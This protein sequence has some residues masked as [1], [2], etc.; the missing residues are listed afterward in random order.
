MGHAFPVL[1]PARALLHSCIPR[2]LPFAPPNPAAGRPALFV[3][4]WATMTESDFLRPDIIGYGSFAFLMQTAGTASPRLVRRGTLPGSRTTMLPHIAQVLRLLPG[5][6]GTLASSAL[7][8][9]R[10]PPSR[11]RRHPGYESCEAQW[12]ACEL[13]CRRF[14]AALTDDRGIAL[15][16]D[17]VRYS[18]I[19]R[20]APR[21]LLCR[22]P[23]HCELI[24]S[25]GEKLVSVSCPGGTIHIEEIADLNPAS[26]IHG[27]G[28]A[29][30]LYASVNP[31]GRPVAELVPDR[32]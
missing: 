24:C 32:F 12:L 13:P 4:F 29:L 9:Y 15:G 16:A 18:L 3:G 27:S 31:K 11:Q 7:R 30:A 5:R 1:C 28:P 22:S 17:A 6:P 19:R 20:T 23:A 21:L 10:L 25:P 8:P 2:P 14:A 26:C